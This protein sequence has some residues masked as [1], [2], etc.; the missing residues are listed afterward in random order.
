[1]D[2]FFGVPSCQ[3]ISRGWVLATEGHVLQT[4]DEGMPP[5]N[6]T[7]DNVY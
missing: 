2:I 5:S 7:I 1:M 6:S 4:S 3:Y